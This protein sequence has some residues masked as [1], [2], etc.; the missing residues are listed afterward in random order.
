MY[1]CMY[2]CM[3]VRRYVCMYVCM[4]VRM[5]V[6]MHVYAHTI[7]ILS[8]QVCLLSINYIGQTAGAPSGILRF[9]TLHLQIG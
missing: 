7:R 9:L 8:G 4:Y 1:V 3:Y 2:V 5:Y 6:C